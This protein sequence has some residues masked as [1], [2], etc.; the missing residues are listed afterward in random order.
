[1]SLQ[2]SVRILNSIANNLSKRSKFSIKQL[3]ALDELLEER[4]FGSGNLERKLSDY[5]EVV[6]LVSTYEYYIE[7]VEYVE[8]VEDEELTSGE[9]IGE[10]N[11]WWSGPG[12]R[13]GFMMYKMYTANR[14]YH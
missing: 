13:S 1:M 6:T 12:K 10:F 8:D 14:L 5:P 3:D 2:S 11:S 9:R 7:E 4:L